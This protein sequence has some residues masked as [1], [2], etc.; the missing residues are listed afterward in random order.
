MNLPF[1]QGVQVEGIQVLLPFVPTFEYVV[2]PSVA[3]NTLVMLALIPLLNMVP[4][5]T[6]ATL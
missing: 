1:L 4:E 3:Y 2:L 6:D 5:T